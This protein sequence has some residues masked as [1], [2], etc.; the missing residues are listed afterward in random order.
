M[1]FIR[2]RRS[3]FCGNQWCQKKNGILER[4]RDKVSS[5]NEWMQSR[6]K[7]SEINDRRAR[8]RERENRAYEREKKKF[9]SYGSSS[10]ALLPQ[11]KKLIQRLASVV[12]WCCRWHIYYYHSNVLCLTFTSFFFFFFFFVLTIERDMA[13]ANMNTNID[14]DTRRWRR[15]RERERFV[16]ITFSIISL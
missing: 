14:E 2:I 10:L 1:L 7:K 15:R 13:R 16:S 12:M 8:T 4:T 6:R 9:Q 3:T 11:Q 5:S